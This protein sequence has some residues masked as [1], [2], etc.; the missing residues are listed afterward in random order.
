[1][2]HPSRPRTWTLAAVL[3][4]IAITSAQADGGRQ[5]PLNA[6]LAY[7][8]ECASCH[9][10]YPPG[11]LPARSWQRVMGGLDK[12]YGTDASLDAATVQQ[13]NAWLQAHAGTY[14]RV[15][16]Q[17]PQDRITRS[18]WFERKHRKVDSSVWKLASVKSAANCAACHT[19][20]DRGDF[21][22]DG[23]EFPEGLDARLRR[24]WND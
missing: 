20:A 19:A 18:A 13:L 8:Q 12:H 21:D 6:P 16:E 11:M 4:L 22:D 24:P 23:L 10:A 2:T 7:T 14:K 15:R 9:T 1:M 3:G 17:P 5:M